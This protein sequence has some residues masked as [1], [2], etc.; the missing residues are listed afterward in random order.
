[1]LKDPM[2]AATLLK[3]EN[4]LKHGAIGVL[5]CDQVSCSLCAAKVAKMPVGNPLGKA[6]AERFIIEVGGILILPGMSILMCDNCAKE[7]ARKTI[8]HI[9][10]ADIAAALVQPKDALIRGMAIACLCADFGHHWGIDEPE[11]YPIA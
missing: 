7:Q 9:D 1:M 6:L 11:C 5:R 8:E 3:L 2:R 4:L 10:G